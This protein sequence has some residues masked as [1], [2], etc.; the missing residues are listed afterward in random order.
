MDALELKR[1]INDP[2]IEAA[3]TDK[4]KLRFRLDQCDNWEMTKSQR[5]ALA[6]LLIRY[7]GYHSHLKPNDYEFKEIDFVKWTRFVSVVL[8]VG[9]KNDEGTMAQ[10]FCRSRIHAFVYRKGGVKAR[11]RI[12]LSSRDRKA[13]GLK[14]DLIAIAY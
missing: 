7:F 11:G 10:L 14:T 13:R 4:T 8:E 12:S 1:L 5:R 6:S 2:V 9:G 3:I